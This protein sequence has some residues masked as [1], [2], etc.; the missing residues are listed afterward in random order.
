MHRRVSECACIGVVSSILGRPMKRQGAMMKVT[1]RPLPDGTTRAELRGPCTAGPVV[2]AP[3]PQK[4]Y[5]ACPYQRPPGPAGA[6]KSMTDF[7]DQSHR[8]NWGQV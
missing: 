6:A 1:L 8:A 7:S 3:R 5:E 4:R 2:C